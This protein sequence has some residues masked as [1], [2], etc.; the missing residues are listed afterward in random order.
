M[1]PGDPFQRPPPPDLEQGGEENV[2]EDFMSTHGGEHN[3]TY[4]YTG[5]QPPPPSAPPVLPTEA[6]FK[7]IKLSLPTVQCT[8]E[9]YADWRHSLMVNFISL[10]PERLQ[11]TAWQY[12]KDIDV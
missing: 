6:D 9:L 2:A 5:Y 4:N 8:A 12:W 7:E 10:C 3:A 1:Y 11:A